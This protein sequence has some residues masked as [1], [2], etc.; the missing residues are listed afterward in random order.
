MLRAVA[1]SGGAVKTNDRV[2]VLNASYEPLSTVAWQRAIVLVLDGAAEV[3]TSD[4]ARPVRSPSFSVACPLVIRLLSFVKVPRRLRVPVT[5]RAV[6]VRDGYRCG[7]CSAKAETIDH[8]VPRSRPG[9]THT[10]DNLVAACKPCNGK[11]RDRTP[12]EADMPLITRP[13]EP[14]GFGA[15]IMLSHATSRREAWLPWLEDKP[16]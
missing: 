1:Q 8:V 15:A 5:R 10:W 6:L 7:Y 3:I 4:E 9:G 11:K 12:D 16:A 2:L 13:Y 14:R